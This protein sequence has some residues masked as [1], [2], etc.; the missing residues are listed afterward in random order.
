MVGCQ[1]V[2]ANSLEVS[3][4]SAA[5]EAV[6]LAPSDCVAWSTR[7]PAADTH[8]LVAIRDSKGLALRAMDEGIL[9]AVQDLGARGP[10]C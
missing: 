2:R 9:L 4:G 7:K 5:L 1:P 8:A 10:R 3:L 6:E